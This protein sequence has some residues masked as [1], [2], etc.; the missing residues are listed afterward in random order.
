[1]PQCRIQW[2][3]G[4]GKLTPDTNE[5]FGECWVEAHKSIM[6]D[7]RCVQFGESEHYPVCREHLIQLREN[8]YKY[9]AW[10]LYSE[11]EV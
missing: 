1:M 6:E 11:P 7:G 9:W 3:D 4:E 8:R 5:A 10:I 2:I